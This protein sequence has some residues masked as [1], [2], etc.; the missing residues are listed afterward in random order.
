MDVAGKRLFGEVCMAPL[1]RAVL[2]KDLPMFL[3]NMEDCLYVHTRRSIAHTRHRKQSVSSSDR[4]IVDPRTLNARED[5]PC[6]A[7]CTTIS[8]ERSKGG[9]FA[10]CRRVVGWLFLDL[11]AWW[12]PSRRSE[13]LRANL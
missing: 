2:M 5:S 8:P 10:K 9:L 6:L 4:Q 7:R 3:L 13:E 12:T 1:A 11:R